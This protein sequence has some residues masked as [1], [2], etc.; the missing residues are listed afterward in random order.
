MTFSN[1]VWW[2]GFFS[3]AILLQRLLPGM[4][5]FVVGLLL[6]LQE[7]RPVQVLVIFGVVLVLQEGVGTLDFGGGL[8]W[9]ASAVLMFFV[10]HWLFETENFMF[11]FMLSGCLGAAHCGVVLL[12]ARLQYFV[13]D[14]PALL[15]EGILQALFIPLVWKI[16]IIARRGM[17]SHENTA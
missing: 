7:R 6:A 1:T 10:G 12:M 5:A 15:D 11:M 14:V 17:V 13:V 3:V 16:A 8:L 2:V 9:Y 4:D